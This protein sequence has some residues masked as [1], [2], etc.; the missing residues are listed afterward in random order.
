MHFANTFH[1][2]V[3]YFSVE[4]VKNVF[5]IPNIQLGGILTFLVSRIIALAEY[6]PIRLTDYLI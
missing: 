3:F 5:L 2:K 1:L 6:Q 4:G